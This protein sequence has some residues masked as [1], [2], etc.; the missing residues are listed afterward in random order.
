MSEPIIL[1]F[2]KSNKSRQRSFELVMHSCEI[3]VKEDFNENK[4]LKMESLRK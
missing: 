2:P 4:H 3:N 1:F